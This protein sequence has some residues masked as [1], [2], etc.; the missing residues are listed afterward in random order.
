MIGF[1]TIATPTGLLIGALC[2]IVPLGAGVHYKRIG[3]GIYG[4]IACLISGFACGFFGGLPMILIT[5]AVVLSYAYVNRAD[6]FTSRA[7][8][9]EVT[10]EVTRLEQLQRA[11][12]N[13]GTGVRGAWRALTRNRAGFVGFLGLVFFFVLTVFGPLFIPYEGA[14]QMDRRQPGARSLVA[15]PSA[16]HILGLDWKGRDVLSHIVHGG[17]RL[18]ATSIMAGVLATVLA[19]SIGALAGLLGGLVDQALS[20][21]A[22]FIL[23][24][25][26]FPLLIVLAALIRLDSDFLLALLFA[27]LNWPTL[28]RAVRAQVLSL[29]E[30]DY[31]QAAIALDLG[32]WHIITREVFPN[33]VSYIAVNLIFTIRIAMY[34]IVGLVFLGLVPLREPDW[35]VMIFTGRQQGV[36]FLPQAA[37]ML[38]SP[39]AAIALFQLSLVL[40]SRSLEEIFNPRLRTGI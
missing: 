37:G 12:A 20:T 1:D 6:P 21:I 39:I 35:G 10:F 27:V 8:L 40:F 17:Q 38:L 5:Y 7:A 18:I 4:A 28:M 13:F 26:A 9:S 30:R 36:L 25:P 24:I 33:L 14:A 2:G 32:L 34:S 29:R 22:N 19:V 11:L 16:E 15:P 23:T 31:V 3:V